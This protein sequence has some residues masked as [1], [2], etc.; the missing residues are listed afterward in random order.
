MT[1]SLTLTPADGAAWSDVQRS[2]IA[3]DL[4]SLDPDL[5]P[6]IRD[7]D[8][9]ISLVPR[10]GIGLDWLI[11]PA[12]IVVAPQVTAVKPARAEQA[13]ALLLQ[14]AGQIAQRHRMLVHAEVLARR[15]DLEADHESLA[16]AWIEHCATAAQVHVDATRA[17]NRFNIVAVAVLLAILLALAQLPIA[18][19]PLVAL[20]ATM[21]LAVL[22]LLWFRNRARRR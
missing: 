14:S 20:A 1:F 7:D 13:F 5:G 16:R 11:E 18:A 21:P 15:V 6:P 12:R 2:A 3:A 9:G 22:V 19:H 17:G 8:G 4:R 10:K